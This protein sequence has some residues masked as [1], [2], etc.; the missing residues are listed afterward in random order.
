M[1]FLPGL[2][3]GYSTAPVTWQSILL[4]FQDLF[5]SDS[6]CWG[7]WPVLA[8]NLICCKTDLSFVA[9]G[10]IL[11]C[12]LFPPIPVK[13]GDSQEQLVPLHP[14]SFVLDTPHCKPQ[15]RGAWTKALSGPCEAPSLDLRVIL[16]SHL[17]RKVFLTNALTSCNLTLSQPRGGDSPGYQSWLSDFHRTRFTPALGT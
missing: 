2:H 12:L 17:F 6:L 8:Q 3:Q 1:K 4:A 13:Q 10:N 16:R 9:W 15:L 7:L 11:G 14:Q 5:S